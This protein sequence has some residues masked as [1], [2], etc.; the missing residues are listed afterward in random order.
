MELSRPYRRGRG[1]EIGRT[2]LCTPF[3]FWQHVSAPKG[4]PHAE[5]ATTLSICARRAVACSST[6]R[7][8]SRHSGSSGH[9]RR[10]IRRRLLVA[11]FLVTIMQPPDA[12][13]GKAVAQQPDGKVVVAGTCTDNATSIHWFCMAVLAKRG[14][15]ESRRGWTRGEFVCDR[16]RRCAT[17]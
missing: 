8:R 1:A 15:R 14:G 6:Q 9:N 17:A 7:N 4:N 2:L 16:V 13:K 11:R 12:N 5:S 3:P 10:N